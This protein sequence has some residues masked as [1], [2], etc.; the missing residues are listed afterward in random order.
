MILRPATL[1]DRAAVVALALAFHGSSPYARLLTV[2]P[3]RLGA[4]FDVALTHGVVIVAECP[5][6]LLT[7]PALVGFFALAALDHGL[8]G[9]RYA[10]ELGWW[11]EPAYRSGTLG[12]QL[13]RQAEAW[14]IAHGCQFLKMVAPVTTRAVRLRSEDPVGHFYELQGYAPIETAYIKRLVPKEAV[15]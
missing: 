6:T 13:L 15:A 5:E 10:E 2:D 12:P 4:S 1:T 7:A 8:S 9:D 14:A 11:V 3:D